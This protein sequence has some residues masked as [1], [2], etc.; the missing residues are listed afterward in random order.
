MSVIITMK[1][2]QG[3]EWR[4]IEERMRKGTKR[5]RKRVYIRYFE[6]LKRETDFC[7]S[8]ALFQRHKVPFV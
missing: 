1:V 4:K 2:K 5:V 3:R 6:Y 8:D 7:K